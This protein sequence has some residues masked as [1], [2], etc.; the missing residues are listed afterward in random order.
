[1]DVLC[2]SGEL[3]VLRDVAERLVYRGDLRPT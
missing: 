2:V 3:A 1:M